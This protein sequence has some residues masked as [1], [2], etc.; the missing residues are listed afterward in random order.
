MSYWKFDNM[1]DVPNNRI[2]PLSYREASV[3]MCA[4]ICFMFSVGF[5]IIIVKIF[6]YMFNVCTSGCWCIIHKMC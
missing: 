5:I 6:V 3:D 1:T 2:L 4:F